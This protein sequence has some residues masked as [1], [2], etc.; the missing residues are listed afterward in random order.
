MDRGKFRE[1]TNPNMFASSV[2]KVQ[3]MKSDPNMQAKTMMI[4]SEKIEKE[5]GM[6]FY[7]DSDAEK[8]ENDSIDD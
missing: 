1:S 8:E 7:G 3:P 2:V 5:L 6:K 4:D